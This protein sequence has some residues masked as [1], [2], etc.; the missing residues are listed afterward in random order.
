MTD[1]KIFKFSSTDSTSL[2]AREYINGGGELPALFTADSQTAGRGRM[3]R[4]FYSPSGEGL[5]MSLALEYEAGCDGVSITATAAVALRRVL[6]GYTNKTLSIK[7]VNDILADGKKT[8]G[9]LAEA[10]ADKDSGKIKA[11]IIGIGVNLTTDS[12]PEE[13]KAIATC[14]DCG[15]ID[16]DALTLEISEELFRVSAEETDSL[17]QEYRRHS[18]VLGRELYYIKN[19][20]RF[21]GVALEILNDGA[22]RVIHSDNT[23]DILISGEITLRVK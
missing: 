19:G 14:L 20:R 10:V 21:D 6:A 12:F 15:K 2:R 4:G 8:A 9:I 11:V 7:W 13:L 16:R 5:Y 18:A 1:L 23:E 22:L 17:M 3:G